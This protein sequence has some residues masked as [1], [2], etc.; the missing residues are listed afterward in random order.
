[1][2]LKKI[3]YLILCILI[4]VK[5]VIYIE[6]EVL[7]EELDIKSK[8]L[9]EKLIYY[10]D[11]K[12]WNEYPDIWVNEEKEIYKNLFSDNKFFEE[13]RGISCVESAK[14]ASVEHI[15]NNDVIRYIN[16]Y[17]DIYEN[18]NAY[19][20]GINYKVSTV[21]SSFYN[22]INYRL[23]LTGVEDNKLK[24]VCVSEAPE[25]LLY[26]SKDEAKQKAVKIIDKRLQGYVVD[27]DFR[28]VENYEDK[29][30]AFN[31]AIE[32][33]DGL[34]SP[35]SFNPGYD[36]YTKFDL[37]LPKEIYLQKIGEPKPDKLSMPIYVKRVLCCEMII[38][39]SGL[40]ALKAQV[41]CAQQFATWNILY[42]SKYPN[43]GYHLTDQPR[44]KHIV[45]M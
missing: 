24:I 7:A 35:M 38:S 20:V 3:V 25:K 13:K 18:I 15:N 40:E 12:M 31:Q 27:G 29:Y 23:V 43:A 19:L 1:M 16:D 36:N 10:E 39:T 11:N 21:S 2:K 22:G 42:Y 33:R 28:V 4:I 17:K 37:Y 32:K 8:N 45:M 5:D 30:V 26:N 6:D 34:I 14:L 41:I 44:D 9:I